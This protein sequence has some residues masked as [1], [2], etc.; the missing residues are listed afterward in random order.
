MNH[1]PGDRPHYTLSHRCDMMLILSFGPFTHVIPVGRIHTELVREK[2]S[3]LSWKSQSSPRSVWSPVLVPDYC[4]AIV[5]PIVD[6][7]GESMTPTH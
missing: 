1:E 3:V 6:A 4:A 5:D 7:I 2:L